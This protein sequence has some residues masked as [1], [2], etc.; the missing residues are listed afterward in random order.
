MKFVWRPEELDALK[1]QFDRLQDA[2]VVAGLYPDRFYNNVC[3]ALEAMGLLPFALRPLFCDPCAKRAKKRRRAEPQT[4][5]WSRQD[6]QQLR[7]LCAD[8]TLSVA[9]IARRTGRTYSAVRSRIK[10]DRIPRPMRGPNG[11]G[12]PSLPEGIVGEYGNALW[13]RTN[14][15]KARRKARELLEAMEA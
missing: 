2:A 5:P 8:E 11:A 13:V 6:L 3:G 9:Q 1:Q 14:D 4:R 10:R 15:Q 12:A 7:A